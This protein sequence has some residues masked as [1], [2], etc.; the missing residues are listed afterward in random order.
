MELQ[1]IQ[2]WRYKRPP[3]HTTQGTVQKSRCPNISQLA[4]YGTMES[5]FQKSLPCFC[6]CPCPYHLLGSHGQSGHLQHAFRTGLINAERIFKDCKFLQAEAGC[7][8]SIRPPQLKQLIGPPM[9]NQRPQRQSQNHEKW[10]LSLPL[11][12]MAPYPC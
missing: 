8:K 1:A 12:G 2:I 10:P 9:V 4:S 5:E 6:S 3:A 7:S 11:P